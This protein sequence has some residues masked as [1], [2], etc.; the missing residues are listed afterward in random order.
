MQKLGLV[1]LGFVAVIAIG[2]LTIQ[3]RDTVTGE[4]YASG[5]GRWYSGPQIVQL[6]PD[7]A[8]L[9]S[10]FEPLYPSRVES[11]KYG[12]LLSICKNGDQFVAVPVVQTVVVP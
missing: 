3:L 11:N 8:C 10:G 9:Y 6:S 5:G 4:Y 12:T 1:L 2:G 7:E